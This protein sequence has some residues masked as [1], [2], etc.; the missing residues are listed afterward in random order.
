M[1]AKENM[2]LAGARVDNL[3]NAGTWTSMRKTVDAAAREY[4]ARVVSGMLKFSIAISIVENLQRLPSPPNVPVAP[5]ISYP[6]VLGSFGRNLPHPSKWSV[7]G[8]P[9]GGL[10]TALREDMTKAAF[11]AAFDTPPP[12]AAPPPPRG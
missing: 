9:A 4:V 1:I 11:R 12:P 7:N 10:D 5:V 8:F 3:P 2:E 6:G